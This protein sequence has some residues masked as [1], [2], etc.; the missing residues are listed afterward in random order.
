[1]LANGIV[2]D[3]RNP[4]SSLRLDA[5]MLAKEA[6]R[7]E[8]ARPERM[9]ELAG[10]MKHTL[11]RMDKV[12][13]EF[14]LLA[15]PG[16]SPAERL[17]LAACARECIEMLA[18]RFEAAGVTPVVQAGSGELIVRASAPAVK[19]ALMNVLLNALQHAGTGGQ[20]RV[21]GSRA[22]GRV[23]LD[24]CDTGPGIPPGSRERIFEMFFTTRPQG[25]G[26]G[27][28]LARTAVENNGGVLGVADAGGPGARLRMEF[29]PAEK[30]WA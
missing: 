23:R 4:M 17:D 20:V 1:M 30:E 8:G 18:P 2:H 14:L 26:L 5:Q 25:T 15:R 10:R 11:D 6:D 9:G 29:P 27:L 22:A 13:Q 3:F 24:I 28:F 21:E 7:S 19:R 12:F 16:E